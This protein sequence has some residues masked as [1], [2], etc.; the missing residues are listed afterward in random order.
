MATDFSTRPKIT[1]VNGKILHNGVACRVAMSR[2]KIS[3]GCT[4][5]SPEAAE[6]IMAAYRSRFPADDEIVIQRQ[7]TIDGGQS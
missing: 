1:L 6:F 4:D 2:S 3:V 5:I 7:E